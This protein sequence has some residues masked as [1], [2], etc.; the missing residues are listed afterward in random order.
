MARDGA[1]YVCQSCG[2][3]HGKWSGQCSACGQWNS[4]VEESRSADGI[5]CDAAGVT[6]VGESAG[7]DGYA[8]RFSLEG[9]AAWTRPVGGPAAAIAGDGAAPLVGGGDAVT[10]L[11]GR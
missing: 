2:A 4:I 11:R 9:V 7:G 8:Q 1:I 3:V 10:R 6:A 5:A